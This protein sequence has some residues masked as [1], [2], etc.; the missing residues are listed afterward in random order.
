MDTIKKIVTTKLNK[1]FNKKEDKKEDKKD[2]KKEDKKDDKK[3]NKFYL[4]IMELDYDC[5]KCGI[6]SSINPTTDDGNRTIICGKCNQ[7]I[8]LNGKTIDKPAHIIKK[9]EID[10]KIKELTEDY[11]SYFKSDSTGGEY[12]TFGSYENRQ[13][14]Y[15]EYTKKVG[16]LER[17][18][19]MI[20]YIKRN[21][22]DGEPIMRLH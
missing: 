8:R 1:V 4:G 13:N 18:K 17:E 21:Y 6:V 12:E 16:Q 22:P 15:I 14:K 2:D 20:G 11:N 3:D 9:A 7:Y 19:D 10:K 5:P